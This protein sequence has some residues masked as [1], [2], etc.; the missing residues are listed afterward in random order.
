MSDPPATVPTIRDA[1]ARDVTAMGRL[2]NAAYQH[3]V[4]RIGKP[5]GPML[6]DYADVV[7]H[8][9]AFIAELGGEVAG[10]LVLVRREGGLLLDNVAVDPRFRGHGLGRRLVAFAETWARERGFDALDLYTHALMVENIA[11][12]QRLGYVETARRE[13]NGYQR[14]YMRKTLTSDPDTPGPFR[15]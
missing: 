12:Y 10:I 8:H 14:V 13:E 5:P 11:L 3:Y 4:Q 2:V 1:S 7:A 15:K 9:H 6:D